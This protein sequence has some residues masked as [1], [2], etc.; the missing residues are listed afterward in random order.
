MRQSH[1]CSFFSIYYFFN[2]I[3]VFKQ[4]KGQMEEEMAKVMEKEPSER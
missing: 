3:S 2:L 4:I 1:C